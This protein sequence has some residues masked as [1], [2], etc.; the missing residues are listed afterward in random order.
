M[1]VQTI[2]R[3]SSPYRDDFRIKAYTFGNGKKTLCLVGTMRGDEIQQQYVAS[4]LV[5]LLRSAEEAGML[6]DKMSISI[7]PSVNPSSINIEK[8]FWA[9]D[10]TDIN[11]MFPG[12][13][14][15]ETTQR[16]AAGV[17]EFIKDYQFG[18]QLASYYLP[19]NF[20]PHV[21][22]FRTG[23]EDI[24][25]ACLFGLP[26]VTV[27]TP[28]PFDT[29]LLNYNWQIWD[30][31]AF[32]LYAGTT[33]VIDHEMANITLKSI[34]RFMLQKG[35]ISRPLNVDDCSDIGQEDDAMPTVIDMADMIDLQAPHAGLLITKVSVGQ[36]I[37]KGDTLAQIMH[38][39]EG[40]ETCRIVAPEDG[41]VFFARNKSITFQ[42]TLLFRLI[43][44]S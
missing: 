23:F 44:C 16:I 2:F 29:V 6:T 22:M 21:H 43:K 24:D 3:M 8:R 31:Q 42:N 27:A 14:Q 35:I 34:S 38:P 41:I 32:S 36:S 19:G 40:R 20:L 13:D 12:Y 1:K 15:G 30:T 25:N 5:A 17:F 37:R 9:L 18:I 10:G 11:R 7:I 28:K 26:Y 39:Y 4:R 33:D